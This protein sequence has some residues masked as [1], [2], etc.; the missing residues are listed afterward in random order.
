MLLTNAFSLNML[1]GDR[2]AVWFEKVDEAFVRIMTEGNLQ[3]AIGHPATASVLSAR[4]GIEIPF[5]RTNVTLHEGD[6]IIVAQV[7]MPRLAEGQILSE[8][9][10]AVIPITYWRVLVE[11]QEPKAEYRNIDGKNTV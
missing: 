3:S 5:N 9:E 10:V 6:D 4:L 8:E 7:T 2:H 1:S 11:S